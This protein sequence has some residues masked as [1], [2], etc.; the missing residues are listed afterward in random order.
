MKAI[1]NTKP[2]HYAE[3]TFIVTDEKYPVNIKFKKTVSNDKINAISTCCAVINATC[4]VGSEVYFDKN[5][6]P[7][8][9]AVIWVDDFTI[10]SRTAEPYDKASWR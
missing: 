9:K 8:A 3:Y 7:H 6:E 1:I 4:S 10:E 2:K 5:H